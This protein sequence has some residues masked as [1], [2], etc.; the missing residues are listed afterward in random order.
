MRA[1]LLATL[2][3]A[4]TAIG[5]DSASVPVLWEPPG[6]INLRDWIWGPGGEARAPKPPYQFIEED[7]NG[8]NPNLRVR[9]AKGDEWTVKF[10]GENHSD[11]FGSRL[12]HAMGYVTEPYYFVASGVI[13]GAR[14]LRRAKPFLDKDGRF[15]YARFKLHDHKMLAHVDGR[16]WSWNDNP[17]LGTR[18]L[19]GLKILMMLT[20]N[21]DCK[22]ARDGA[23][24][25]TS[26]YSK[27]GEGAGQLYYAFDDW[28]ASMGKWGGFFAR[29]KWDPAGYQAQTKNFA[30]IAGQAI[31]W[32][33]Q[34]KH[35]NDITTGISRDDVRWLLTYLSAVTGEELQA[36]LRASGARESDIAV[37]A[38]CLRERIQ[39]LERI[40]AAPAALR[41]AGPFP[42]SAVSQAVRS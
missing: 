40:A 9:D 38:G 31:E 2:S 28:G 26:V 39:Q 12:L 22:D 11:V 1:R 37:F 13:T 41:A 42:K 29:D 15:R 32:G 30:R 20:S 16:T 8:T 18:E 34:G 21:W 33:Y 14:G 19:S 25:N 7:F 4:L 27:P 3:L 5:A 17:F 6:N 36:G 24:S 35:G 10:G 23:G